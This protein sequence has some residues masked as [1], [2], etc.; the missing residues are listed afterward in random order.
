MSLLVICVE[1]RVVHEPLQAAVLVS[2]VGAVVPELDVEIYRKVRGGYSC[3]RVQ[4]LG[5]VERVLGIPFSVSL[6]LRIL[7]E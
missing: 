4:W 2:S 1:G 3:E 7:C 6:L 5:Q